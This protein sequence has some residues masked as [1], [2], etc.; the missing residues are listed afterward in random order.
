MIFSCIRLSRINKGITHEFILYSKQLNQYRL[1]FLDI[2]DIHLENHLNPS[3]I[4]N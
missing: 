4:K 3:L 2:V 1:G